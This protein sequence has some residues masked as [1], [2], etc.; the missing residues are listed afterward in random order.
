MATSPSHTHAPTALTDLSTVLLE[1]NQSRAIALTTE[2]DGNIHILNQ[3]TDV[4]L[5]PRSSLN[6]F[7]ISRIVMANIE[8]ELT[9]AEPRCSASQS[10]ILPEELSIRSHW[11]LEHVDLLREVRVEGNEFG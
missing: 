8:T 6:V 3:R 7:A 11:S 10:H 2:S 5:T 4:V 1:N 9:R